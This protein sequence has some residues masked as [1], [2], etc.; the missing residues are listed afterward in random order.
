MF[1]NHMPDHTAIKDLLS[2][3]SSA[4]KREKKKY[5]QKGWHLHP[6]CPFNG[7]IDGACAH[8]EAS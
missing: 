8:R 2:F 3:L 6:I 7:S 4:H 5:V 1:G